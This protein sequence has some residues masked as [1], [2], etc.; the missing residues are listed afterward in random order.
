MLEQVH[1]EPSESSVRGLMDKFW[2]SWQELSIR[3][4]DNS[5]REA[6]LSRGQALTEGIR[7]RY[8]R[9]SDFRTMVD[10]DLRGTVSQVNDLSKQIASLSEEIV[11]SKALGDSPN[12]LL[13]RRDLLVE[14]LGKLVPITADRRDADEFMVHVDGLVLVQGKI[15]RGFEMAG[16]DAEGFATPVWSDTK[17]GG[18]VQGRDPRRPDRAPGRRRAKRAPNPRHHVPSPSPTSSTKPTAAATAPTARRGRTSSRSGPSSTTS[19]AIT[20]AQATEP[21]TRAISTA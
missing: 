8:R 16:S 20:T 10:G 21:T 7:D 11:K 9:L 4:E 18:G 5:A 19:R 17:A 3:P 1:N 6:V 13:D 15:A 12:D 2:D 14:K